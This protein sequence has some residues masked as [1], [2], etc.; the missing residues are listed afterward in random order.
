MGTSGL[1]AE[2]GEALCHCSP[3]QRFSVKTEGLLK[4]KVLIHVNRRFLKFAAKIVV[5]TS[6]AAAARA[7]LVLAYGK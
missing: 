1:S 7:V 6:V 3:Y 5:V 2:A 4:I